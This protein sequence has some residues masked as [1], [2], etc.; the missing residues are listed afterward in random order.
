MKQDDLTL[1]LQASGLIP[2]DVVCSREYG[3]D[4][5]VQVINDDVAVIEN[6]DIFTPIHDDPRVQ[7]EIVACNA[8][9]DVFAM[10]ATKILSMQAFMAYPRHLPRDIAAGVLQGMTDF[11]KKLD[12]KVTGGQ[13]ITNPEP[14]FGGICLGI[15]H[16][17]DVI[18]SSGAKAGDSVL[19]TKPL[20]IQPAMRSYRDLRD[21]KR[22]TLLAQFDESELRRIEKSAVNVMT[23][24]NR[25]VAAAMVEIGVNAATDITGFGIIGHANNVAVL[26]GVDV[27]IDTLPII[28]GTSQLAEYFGHKL[29][30]GQSAET[31]GGMLIFIE[32]GR[33]GTLSDL[34]KKKGIQ[35]W[36][37]GVTTKA[38]PTPQAR[39]ADDVQI[40][41]TDFL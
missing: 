35:C 4:A 34:L 6:V 3:E 41:E 22:D 10:G 12:S 14:V 19:L 13:T 26:S 15:A 23:Q 24:S 36:S 17:K 32:S 1:L 28:R 7:G 20:G 16:P 37:V 29:A 33:A 27:V 9:N 11:M 40:I 38:S 31:A 25:E 30:I 2:T 39:L 18:Y 8:T 5:V 21:E